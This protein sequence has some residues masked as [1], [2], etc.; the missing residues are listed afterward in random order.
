MSPKHWAF[1]LSFLLLAGAATAF[2]HDVDATSH[3]SCGT[4]MGS[5][6]CTWIEMDGDRPVELGASIPLGLIERVPAD[7]EMVWPP[8]ELAM[9][10]LPAVAQNALGLDHLG[11]NWEA[12]GHPPQ[13]FLTQHFDFHFYNLTPDE[14]ASIDCS[15][16]A[17][18]DRLPDGYALPDVEVPG[19]GTLVGLCVPAM[20]MHAMEA[21]E[22]HDTAP[23]QAS[24][25]LGYYDG[26]PIFFE[27][28]VARDLLMQKKDFSLR[29]PALADL[30]AGVRYPTEFRAEYDRQN[31]A[32]RLLF[33][34][35]TGS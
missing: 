33:T 3:S 29:M 8:R 13:T 14:V 23:F 30:P 18:P 7:A 15:D 16:D 1:A 2:T 26:E 19:L 4:V 12:H 28:M 34:G 20:G 21:H 25:M 31:Q 35:F 24:M 5:E 6:V 9:V 10:S 22:V 11:I 17:K 32:Y 27:P